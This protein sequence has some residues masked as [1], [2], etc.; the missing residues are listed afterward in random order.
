M[1]LAVYQALHILELGLA[2]QLVI[3]VR[4]VLVEHLYMQAAVGVPF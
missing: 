1:L 4:H 2:D 3:R